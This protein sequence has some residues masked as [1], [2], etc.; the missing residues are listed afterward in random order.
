MPW[1][2]ENLQCDTMMMHSKTSFK[3][4]LECDTFCLTL[5]H[6]SCFIAKKPQSR[7]ENERRHAPVVGKKK[8]KKKLLVCKTKTQK[9]AALRTS[10]TCLNASDYSLLFPF[11]VKEASMEGTDGSTEMKWHVLGAKNCRRKDKSED[12]HVGWNYHRIVKPM[13]DVFARHFIEK[14]VFAEDSRA[15]FFFSS[16]MRCDLMFPVLHR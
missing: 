5:F 1:W 12:E 8:S 9:L 6:S 14:R 7:T 2:T 10:V 4:L 3:D 11:G 15:R 16:G 13:T